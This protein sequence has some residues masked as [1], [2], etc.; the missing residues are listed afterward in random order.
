MISKQPETFSKTS[1]RTKLIS[2]RFSLALSLASTKASADKSLAVTLPHR[3]TLF[4]GDR[5]STTSSAYIKN[6]E[7]CV[8]VFCQN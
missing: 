3:T 4:Q 5:N 7:L 1:A 8:W 2:T 6:L